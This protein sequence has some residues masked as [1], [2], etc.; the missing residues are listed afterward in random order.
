M[1]N[2]IAYDMLYDMVYH[3]TI[4]MHSIINIAIITYICI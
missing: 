1:H 4:N 2:K 3:T